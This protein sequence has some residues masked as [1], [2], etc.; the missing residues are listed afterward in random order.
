MI[1][2]H[3]QL[4]WLRP[5]GEGDQNTSPNH[6][7]DQG[8]VPA[9]KVMHVWY[10][11]SMHEFFYLLICTLRVYFVDDSTLVRRTSSVLGADGG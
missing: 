8:P 6:V 1:L 2:G 11:Y 4:P 3:R 7:V 9:G 5:W 10:Q